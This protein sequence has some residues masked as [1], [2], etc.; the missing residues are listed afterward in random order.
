MHNKPIINKILFG[1]VLSGL[2]LMNV[3]KVAQA[4]KLPFNIPTQ[5]VKQELPHAFVPS[6]THS[7][8]NSFASLIGSLISIVMPVAA[9]LLLLY[10][11][12]GAIEWIT[13]GGDKGKLEKSRQRITTGVIGIIIVSATISLFMLMQQIL[14]ICILDFWGSNSNCTLPVGT[15]NPPSGGTPPSC[16]G[17][18]TGA[19]CKKPT[20]CTG[21]EFEDAAD[22]CGTGKVCCL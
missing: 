10:L 16:S 3:S 4:A 8:S 17:K 15:E 19:S 2:V 21:G 7:Y 6:E 9:L 12:W 11:I 1:I 22:Y 14:N 5:A 13:S 18:H 20:V